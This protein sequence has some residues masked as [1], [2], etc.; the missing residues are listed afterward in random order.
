MM[1]EL[2]VLSLCYRPLIFERLKCATV[3]ATQVPRIV[4]S[5]HSTEGHTYNKL[6]CLRRWDLCCKYAAH[7]VRHALPAIKCA[8]SKATDHTSEWWRVDEGPSVIAIKVL[9]LCVCGGPFALSA[10]GWRVESADGL[11]FNF[12]TIAVFHARCTVKLGIF[13]LI[14][15]MNKACMCVSDAD[16]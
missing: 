4:Q 16:P 12:A 9:E 5:A 14:G 10:L 15:K 6:V 11:G 7:T 13:F 2:T 1:Y 8:V 3:W